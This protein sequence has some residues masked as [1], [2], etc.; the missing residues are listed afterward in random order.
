[1]KHP[2]ETQ[3]SPATG[4]KVGGTT[5]ESQKPVT[6]RDVVMV[7]GAVVLA[8][9]VAAYLNTQLPDIRSAVAEN[10]QK[11]AVIETEITSLRRDMERLEE[12]DSAQAVTPNPDQLGDTI[13]AASAD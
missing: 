8:F 6:V 11:L 3:D 5:S 10:S 7:V 12:H 2:D 1:M 4:D 9:T 13:H